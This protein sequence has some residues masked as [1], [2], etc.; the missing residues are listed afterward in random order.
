MFSHVGTCG[1]LTSTVSVREFSNNPSATFVRA[2]N[3]ETIE[4]T[5]HGKVIATLNRMIYLV[6]YDRKLATVARLRGLPVASP[7]MESWD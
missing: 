3:G 6:T 2:E 1:A 7:D 4:I 5:R